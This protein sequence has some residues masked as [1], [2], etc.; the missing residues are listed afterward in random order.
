VRDDYEQTLAHLEASLQVRHLAHRPLITVRLEA[1]P[2]E[3]QNVAAAWTMNNLPVVAKD[4]AIVGVL[5]NVNGE[6]ETRPL[7]RDDVRRVEFSMQ[8]LSDRMLVESQRSLE[9]LLDELLTPPYYQL[10]VTAGH[11]D[12]IVTASDLNK[13]PVRVMAYATIAHL[14]TV[15][16]AAIREKTDSDDAAAVGELRLSGAKQVNAAYRKLRRGDLNATLLDATTFKQ[17][18]VILAELG[19][20][21]PCGVISVEAEFD[22]LYKRL[23]NPLM[24]A[25][26]FVADSI[27][28]LRDFSGLLARARARA[29]EALAVG[30]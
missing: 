15:M 12:G 1:T 17:K 19:I 11:I 14:E 21:A 6:I 26:P 27:A 28:G 24:H 30:P 18:G 13:A 7:P 20:F 25:H 8:P 23:R 29:A 3:A 9:G 22:A 2:E 4:G 10:V 5:E 16:T